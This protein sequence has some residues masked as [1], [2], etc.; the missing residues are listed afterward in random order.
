LT[1][2]GATQMSCFRWHHH[3]HAHRPLTDPV[4]ALAR[5]SVRLHVHSAFPRTRRDFSG[6]S[7]VRA[8]SRRA[9]QKRPYVRS[10]R[11]S[12][13]R[14]RPLHP[15]H[16]APPRANIGFRKW[17]P[18]IN[19]QF[20]FASP[21]HENTLAPLCQYTGG[22]ALRLDCMASSR[23]VKVERPCCP[24]AS[25]IDRALFAKGRR[26]RVTFALTSPV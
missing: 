10:A 14:H 17:G 20:P 15:C 18:I 2:C 23:A 7:A 19:L 24:D 9:R 25:T 13:H 1:G 5:A 3:R 12:V 16:L 4:T 11:R 6:S 22:R 21:M 8:A 26:L